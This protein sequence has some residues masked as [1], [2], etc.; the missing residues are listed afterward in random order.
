LSESKE[1]SVEEVEERVEIGESEA[2]EEAPADFVVDVDALEVMLRVSDLL[3]EATRSVE[4]LKYI[5][6]IES[7][8]SEVMVKG[9][10]KVK[11][12]GKESKE[13]KREEK[14]KARSRKRSSKGKPHPK[15]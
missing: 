7:V 9:R 2:L 6:E 11:K 10:R 14:P 4:H 15:G 8:Q 12:V 1:E 13:V 5:K 3:V